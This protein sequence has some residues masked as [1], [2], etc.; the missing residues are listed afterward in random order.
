MNWYSCAALAGL[1]LVGLS[2]AILPFLSIWE[3]RLA[4]ARRRSLYDKCAG[5]VEAL[6]ALLQMLFAAAIVADL[7]M[8][9]S[10]DRLM[11]GPWR[12]FWEVLACSSAAA[13]LFSVIATFTKGGVRG[14]ASLFSG[15][16]AMLSASISCLLGW[17]FL[18]G[19]LEKSAS[20]AEGVEQ[21]FVLV[22]TAAQSVMFGVFVLFA[23]CL[24]VAGAYALTL[25]WH[26][27]CRRKDDFGRDY[28]TFV[29]GMRARQGCHAGF[30][31]LL[32]AA[33]LSFFYPMVSAEQALAVLPFAGEHAVLALTSGILCLPISALSLNDVAKASVPMQKRSLAFLGAILLVVGV[34]CVI[35][36]L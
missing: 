34:Y 26:I 19:A 33:V 10:I 14:F 30:L 6:T 5:Q 35:G 31:L 17:A 4:I 11:V 28:Y 24:A 13:A 9:G 20:G 3:H 15:L 25:C 23:V 29:L 7:A 22:L 32:A 18:M 12:F 21:A 36:R 1:L 8:G 16:S 27:L 2:G